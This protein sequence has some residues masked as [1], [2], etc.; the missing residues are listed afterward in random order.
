LIHERFGHDQHAALIWQLFHIRQTRTVNEYV[1]QFSE[2]VDQLM[3]YE[4][5]ANPLY[6]AMHF[7]DGLKQDIRSMVMIQ[8]PAMLDAACAPTL[9]QEEATDGGRRREFHRYDQHANKSTPTLAFPLPLP[10]V[11]DKPN[12]LSTDEKRALD[13]VKSQSTDDKFRAIRQYRRARGLCD[14]CAEKWVPCHRC[15]TTVQLHAV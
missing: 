11:P 10:P 13:Y 5:D 1:I 7:V 3:S 15:V 4:S 14:R 12:S 2:L 9:V 8:R 6:Y